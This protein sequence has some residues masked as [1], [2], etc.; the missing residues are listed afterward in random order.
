MSSSESEYERERFFRGGG[1]RASKVHNITGWSNRLLIGGGYGTYKPDHQSS[2][3]PPN[4]PT[5]SPSPRNLAIPSQVPPYPCAP[6]APVDAHGQPHGGPRSSSSS[7]SRPSLAPSSSHGETPTPP[8][9]IPVRGTVAGGLAVFAKDK[10]VS[11][12]YGSDSI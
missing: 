8:V 5:I 6:R 9:G 1:G 3:P 4:A 11:M 7:K 10:T 12:P 2:F